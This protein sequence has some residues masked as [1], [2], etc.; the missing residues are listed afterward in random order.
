MPTLLIQPIQTITCGKYDA[1]IIGI[2]PGATDHLVGYI[3]T[4]DGNYN[5]T[6]S[7]SGICRDNPAEFNLNC[8]SEELSD[9]IDK[10]KKISKML[11]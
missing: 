11:G 3:T 9:L 8:Q 1:E 10:A 5:A 4:S 7:D 6:W 2:S